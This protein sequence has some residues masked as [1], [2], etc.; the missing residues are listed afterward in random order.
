MP[1]PWDE[2]LRFRLLSLSKDKMEGS[3]KKGLG[4]GRCG[5]GPLCCGSIPFTSTKKGP[6]KSGP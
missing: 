4:M 6:E 1:L 3:E 5:S 2:T